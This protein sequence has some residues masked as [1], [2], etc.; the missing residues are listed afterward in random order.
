MK[1]IRAAVVAAAVLAGIAVTAAPANAE[2]NCNRASA[3]YIC[4]YGVTVYKYPDGTKQEF[5]VGAD[6]AVWSRYNNTK[7]KWTGWYST[8]GNAVSRIEVGHRWSAGDHWGFDI[9][10]RHPDGAYRI[11]ARNHEGQWTGW[12]PV[13]DPV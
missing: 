4:E 2:S 13:P 9:V 6:H 5:L 8:G 3:T 10:A 12:M 7:G 1:K 11:N